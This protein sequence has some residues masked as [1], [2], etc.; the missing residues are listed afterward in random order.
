MKPVGQMVPCAPEG[1]AVPPV[2][3]DASLGV[4]SCLRIP[5]TAIGS[6][7]EMSVPKSRQ[8]TKGTGRP[9]ADASSQNIPPTTKADETV[10]A[11]ASVAMIHFC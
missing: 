5:S 4:L 7:G 11:V 1:A 2:A 9:R 3:E 8:Y 6:V 10:P